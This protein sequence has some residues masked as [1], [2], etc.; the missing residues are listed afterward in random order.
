M[1]GTSGSGAKQLF[2][3]VLA[4]GLLAAGLLAVGSARE[5]GAVPL[6]SSMSNPA[7]SAKQIQQANPGALDGLYW[8]DP[9]GGSPADAFQIVADMTTAGGGWT[10]GV[11]GLF[12]SPAR[13][14]DITANSGTVGPNSGHNRD[15]SQLAIAQD[16]Q[17]R[18][19]LVEANGNVLLDAF[20]TGNYHGTVAA[21]GGWTVLQ[22]NLDVLSYRGPSNT[23]TPFGILGN[24]WSTASNDVDDFPENCATIIG[25]PWYYTDCATAMPVNLL[26]GGLP[27]FRGQISPA[28]IEAINTLPTTAV[29]IGQRNHDA[30][31]G[32]LRPVLHPDNEVAAAIG[33]AVMRDVSRR[34]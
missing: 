34:I 10:L 3:G 29:R 6:G 28:N 13:S 8:I 22:G 12:N 5:A 7:F 18:H 23:P 4:A 2:A 32:N 17:I 14:T 26:A 16:A 21:A 33:H 27:I 31:Y 19:R 15:L 20:Y 30:S 9:N 24:D 11:N 25:V 1:F